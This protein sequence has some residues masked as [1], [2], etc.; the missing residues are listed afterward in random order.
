MPTQLGKVTKYE[1]WEDLPEAKPLPPCPHLGDAVG[2]SAEVVCI[3]CGGKRKTRSYPIH[4]CALFGECLPK[5]ECTRESKE[6][7]AEWMERQG[8]KVALTA[9]RGCPRTNAPEQFPAI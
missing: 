5:Y 6:A 9:C 3:C 8:R 4:A 7:T 1:L 2:E